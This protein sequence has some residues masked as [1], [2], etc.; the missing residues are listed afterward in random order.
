MHR[1]CTVTSQRC[2]NSRFSAAN[3]ANNALPAFVA[4]HSTSMVAR[5][6]AGTGCAHRALGPWTPTPTPPAPR[7]YTH[8]TSPTANSVFGLLHQIMLR[9][10]RGRRGAKRFPDNPVGDAVRKGHTVAHS[11]AGD[12]SGVVSLP[13]PRRS[14]PTFE[15]LCRIGWELLGEAMREDVQRSEKAKEPPRL[16]PNSKTGLPH[17]RSVD[18]RSPPSGYA[19][20][21]QSPAGEPKKVSRGAR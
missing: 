21:T 7:A 20:E 5:Y 19:G 3:A 17:Y 15:E 4:H 6:S 16:P 1:D 18:R 13:V 14:V 11:S 10:Q 9:Y 2:T 8:R 12:G